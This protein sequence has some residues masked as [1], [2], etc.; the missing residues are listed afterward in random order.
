VM[1]IRSK[2]PEIAASSGTAKLQPSPRA[3]PVSKM[4]FRTSV[5]RLELLSSSVASPSY[6]KRPSR[7][8]TTLP[9]LL[10]SPVGVSGT[11][12][13]DCRKVTTSEPAEPTMVDWPR[14]RSS[15]ASSCSTCFPGDPY[16]D[17]FL[18]STDVDSD[19]EEELGQCS[20]RFANS[21]N[22]TSLPADPYALAHQHALSGPL[23]DL[24]DDSDDDVALGAS[25]SGTVHDKSQA[26]MQRPCSLEPM[27]ATF[28]TA[29]QRAPGLDADARE[30]LIS[31]LNNTSAT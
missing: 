29:L 9:T 5:A 12:N 6:S 20:L 14:A 11:G 26:E 7:S 1:P 10:M 31:F 13:W 27:F 21:T 23:A 4:L 16:R 18:R 30:D 25:V 15:P 8:T 28:V 19:S 22:S 2:L 24:A 3:S 17:D